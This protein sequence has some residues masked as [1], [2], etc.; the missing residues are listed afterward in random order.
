MS[1]LYCDPKST[2]ATASCVVV[3]SRAAAATTLAAQPDPRRGAARLDADLAGFLGGEQEVLELRK[4]QLLFVERRQRGGQ[5][6]LDAGSA[7]GVAAGRDACA[8]R[9]DQRGEDL[10]ERALRRRL[11]GGRL[12]RDRLAGLVPR[13]LLGSAATAPRAPA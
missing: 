2:M 10:V 13:T 12:G 11:S 7:G 3:A 8:D 9:I 6:R 5:A 4:A 1:W